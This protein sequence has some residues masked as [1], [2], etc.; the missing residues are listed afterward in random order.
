MPIPSR[1]LPSLVWSLAALA[2]PLG[3]LAAA[4]GTAPTSAPTLEERVKAL[5]LQV[6]TEHQR[7][8]TSPR[9]IADSKNGFA[10]ASAD[11]TYV[12]K[13]WGYL[14]G[15]GRFFL[16]DEDVPL[17]NTLVLRRARIIAEGKVGPFDFR[18]MPDFGNG[19]TVLLDAF[20]AAPVRPWFKVQVG[21]GKVPVGLEF[22]QSDTVTTFIERAY[23]T[24]LVPNRDNGVHVTG[25]IAGGLLNYTIGVYNGAADGASRDS[26]NTDDKDGVLRL[27]SMPFAGG[28]PALAGLLI[29]VGASYGTD[30]GVGTATA[31]ASSGLS[32]YRSPGQ[33][34]IFTY[35]TTTNIATTVVADGAR[36]RLAPQLYYAA[37]PFS[38]MAEYT[39]SSVDVREVANSE[40][41]V[42]Q[43]WQVTATWTLTGENASFKGLSPASPLTFDGSGWGAFELAA[44]VHRLD[45]DQD[46]F[47]EGFANPAT[48]VEQATGY[49]VALNWYMTRNVKMKLNVERTVYEGGAAAG[50]DREDENLIST[51][52][53]LVY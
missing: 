5:E 48:S 41:L 7:L 22:L 33:A 1:V 9:G 15:E 51:Q 38:A 47:D 25:D 35:D 50:G 42:N 26:D 27:T 2:T 8:D 28:H 46:A 17:T 19:Q 29:G 13:V 30:D 32:T 20:V 3:T 12:L 53:Q 52:V 34:T 40:T 31:V 36:W 14:Q 24:Q 21:R 23:P 43:A 4:E 45:I 39:R 44:R 16:D 6:A 18:V 49:A 37:G 10:I 11:G